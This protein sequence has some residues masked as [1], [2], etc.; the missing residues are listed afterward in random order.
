[1]TV[2]LKDMIGRQPPEVQEKIKAR[3]AELIA[4]E[5]ARAK[6]LGSEPAYHLYVDSS[7]NWRWQLIAPTGKILAA[8]GEAYKTKRT[9][10][11]SINRVRS[12]ACAEMV[13]I[14]AA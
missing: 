14:E 2:S 11:A 8:S 6:H 10:L 5:L 7:G 1:M 4:E 12:A 9:C 3:T 13:V